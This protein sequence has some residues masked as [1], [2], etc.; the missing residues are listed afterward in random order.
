MRLGGESELL[1]GGRGGV[2]QGGWVE[3]WGGVV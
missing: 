2:G 3:E 1:E